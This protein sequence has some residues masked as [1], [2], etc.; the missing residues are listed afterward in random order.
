MVPWLVFTVA[1]PAQQHDKGY[2][3]VTAGPPTF[4]RRAFAVFFLLSSLIRGLRVCWFGRFLCGHRSPNYDEA[5]CPDLQGAEALP[6]GPVGPGWSQRW[7]APLGV[8]LE[9]G[10]I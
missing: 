10:A 3:V 8:W 2:G 1:L 6:K 7:T 9:E 5:L 4:Q